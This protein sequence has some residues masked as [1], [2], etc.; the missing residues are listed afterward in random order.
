MTWL[1]RYRS[2]LREGGV[3][4][5]FAA[6]LVG[7]LSL[8]MTSLA[9]LLL[10]RQSTGSYGAAGAVSAAYAIAFAI[11]SPSRARSA[12]RRGPVS[13]LLRCAAVQPAALTVL[14]VLA[15]RDW[16]L[17]VLMVP[18]VLGGL[19]VPPIG[20]VM[21]ALWAARL[22]VA[23]LPTAYS[24]ESVLVELCFL[25]GPAMCRR[26]THRYWQRSSV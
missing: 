10:V 1:D 9:I 22:P 11:G 4:P 3:A 12:D 24:L 14:A 25:V 2:V 19:F 18:A 20:A 5:A 15:D 6:S 23:S 16:P 7:R 26:A 17:A 13:I 21:R 8:G